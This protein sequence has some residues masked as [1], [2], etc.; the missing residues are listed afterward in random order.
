MTTAP[1]SLQSLA[2]FV[3]ERTG[4]EFFVANDTDIYGE[5]SGVIIR[6]GGGMAIVFNPVHQP[7]SVGVISGDVWLSKGD[8]LE[9]MMATEADLVE[10]LAG[11]KDPF[12]AWR[13]PP[14]PKPKRT[15][16]TLSF[17]G[18]EVVFRW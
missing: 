7:F 5:N 18:L 10:I 15:R 13:N 9:N 1:R 14:A 12:D 17:L 3:T 6:A 2:Q 8:K 4:V 11:R 16:F